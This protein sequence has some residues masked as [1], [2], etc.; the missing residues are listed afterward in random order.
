MWKVSACGSEK[1]CHVRITALE[2]S[3]GHVLTHKK[4]GTLSA[5]LRSMQKVLGGGR[6]SRDSCVT[7]C[8]AQ[9]VV[10]IWQS[11]CFLLLLPIHATDGPRGYRC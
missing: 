11:A 8:D 4:Y 9:S 3:V 1:C 6:G 10:E 2:L 5:V 7:P